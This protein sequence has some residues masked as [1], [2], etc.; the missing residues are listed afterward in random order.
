M[1]IISFS[2]FT[3]KILFGC[4]GETNLLSWWWA[5]IFLIMIRF[6]F[7]SKNSEKW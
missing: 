5:F 1:I 4:N 2:L 7:L 6:L 3:D